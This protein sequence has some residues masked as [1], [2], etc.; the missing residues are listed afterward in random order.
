M[1]GYWAME[2][3]DGAGRG[4]WVCALGDGKIHKIAFDNEKEKERGAWAWLGGKGGRGGRR[5]GFP[6]LV[7]VHILPSTDSTPRTDHTPSIHHVN[8]ICPTSP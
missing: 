1:V 2:L 3:G 6:S 5:A 7:S 8:I 4:S